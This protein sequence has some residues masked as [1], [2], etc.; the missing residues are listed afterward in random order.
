M[1]TE[2]WLLIFAGISATADFLAILRVIGIGKAVEGEQTQLGKQSAKRKMA[3]PV[4]LFVIT[5]GLIGYAF[6]RIH[7]LQT[8]PMHFAQ[9]N[10]EH[11][12][13]VRDRKYFREE[14]IL[15][16]VLFENCTF[17]D[18]TLT[19]NGTDEVGFA[20]TSFSNVRFKNTSDSIG[21]AMSLLAAFGYFKPGVPMEGPDGK[22][23]KPMPGAEHVGEPLG[24]PQTH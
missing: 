6:Y 4:A 13:I 24:T 7:V 19:Y 23:M 15:D 10:V 12:K 22:P 8:E 5:M 21:V 18:V 3:L 16:G 17:D 11:L 1:T 9:H 14:V 20:N 2:Q